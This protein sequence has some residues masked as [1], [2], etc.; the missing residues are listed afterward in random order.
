MTAPRAGL[1]RRTGVRA[2][3]PAP[4]GGQFR[5]SLSELVSR[6]YGTYVS[7]L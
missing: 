4:A 3:G 5:Q 7:H 2:G 6:P 1:R